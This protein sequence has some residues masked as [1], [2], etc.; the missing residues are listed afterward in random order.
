M[1]C[2]PIQSL[3]QQQLSWDPFRYKRL[4]MQH[5]DAKQPVHQRKEEGRLDTAA[6]HHLFQDVHRM[7]QSQEQLDLEALSQR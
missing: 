3:Q 6:L 5:G 1:I 4:A 7:E 2:H